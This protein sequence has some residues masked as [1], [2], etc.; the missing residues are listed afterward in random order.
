MR[1][2]QTETNRDQPLPQR[3]RAG[4]PQ[5]IEDSWQQIKSSFV[6]DPTGAIAAAEEL[7][8]RTVEERMRALHD[9]ATALCARGSDDESASTEGLRARLLRYQEYCARSTVH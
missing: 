9:E 8:R 6:D 3:E 4:S 5:V 7:V 2:D 1:P